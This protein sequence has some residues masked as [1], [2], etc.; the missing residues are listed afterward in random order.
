MA[1]SY[2]AHSQ[3]ITWNGNGATTNWSDGDNWNGGVAPG[4]GNN[5]VF[6]SS[7]AVVTF[8][9]SPTVDIL[10]IRP[11]RNVV[12]DIGTQT[13][14]VAADKSNLIRIDASTLEIASGTLTVTAPI[15]NRDAF[16][17]RGTG[18][19][20]NVAEGATLNVTGRKGFTSKADAL[21]GAINNSGVINIV[22]VGGTDGIVLNNSDPLTLINEKCAV[23]NLGTSKIKTSTT[24]ASNIT[25]NGLVTLSV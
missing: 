9:T 3:S 18:S 8:I 21:D 10:D 5:A 24:A 4:A 23:I 14:T 15:T 2:S 16:Q 7:D 13:L 19:S 6:L 1:F 20:F 12:L 17:F 25:N 22:S 11:G